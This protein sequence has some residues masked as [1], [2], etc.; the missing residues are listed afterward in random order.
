VTG[1]ILT[2]ESIITMDHSHSRAQAV[3][4]SE[5]RIVAVGSLAECLA[6]LPGAEVV[7]TG[8]AALLPGFIESHSHPIVS[9]LATQPPALSIAPWKATTWQQVLDVFADAHMS[10]PLDQ[11]LL[12]NGFDALLHKQPS[13]TAE[14][15]DAIFGDRVVVVADNSGHGVYF[16]TALIAKNGWDSRPPSD[17][18]GGSFGRLAGGSSLDGQ[19]FELPAVMAVV[20]PVLNELGGNPL[21]MGMEYY[22]LM[23][24]AGITSA[25]ELTYNTT[26]KAAYEAVAVMPNNPLR[27]SL[28]HVS[29]E[30]G[31]DLPLDSEVSEELLV[32]QGIK[33]W[34]DGSPWIGNIAIGFPYLD[35]PTTR[36]AKIDGSSAGEKAMNYS[37]AQLD[38]ILDKYA[39]SGLQM[40]FHVNGDL[41][42]DI[43]LDAYERA[44]TQHELLGT[45]H[46]WRVEHVGACRRDQFER[47]ASLGVHIS[48]GP[49]QFYYWGD[50]LDGEMFDSRIGSQWQAFRDAFDSGAP[51]AFHNDGSVSPP[52]PLLNIQTAVTRRTSSGTERGPS[53]AITLHEAVQAQTINAARLLKREGLVGSIE[54]GKLADFVELSADPFEVDPRTLADSVSVLGTWLGGTRIDL[55][56]FMEQSHTVDH[57]AHAELSHTARSAHTC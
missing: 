49:F 42:F 27:V 56:D 2:A 13:P 24:R 21:H 35:T 22:A 44:L 51:V 47:A 30:D 19:A 7:D 54:V 31:C 28:Y 43:V 9:G 6:A 36:R 5:G 37:R 46:R 41:G 20:Q 55:D 45:D 50:L 1:S 53:Q 48:M 32:K 25:S 23:S 40:A 18:V 4:V 8:A 38:A 33:L 11:P 10:T 29:V 16:S 3:A 15:L 34:A 39:P 12:F 17:P 52:T 57:A 14:S 26:L